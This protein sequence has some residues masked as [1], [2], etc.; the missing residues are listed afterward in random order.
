[1]V[2]DL[3]GKVL[4]PN[5]YLNTTGNKYITRLS[6][7]RGGRRIQLNMQFDCPREA[8]LY[9]EIIKNLESLWKYYSMSTR[10]IK[11]VREKDV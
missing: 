2:K 9:S 10:K 3:S 11:D 1:M 5:V 4:P 6:I 8:C 7:R